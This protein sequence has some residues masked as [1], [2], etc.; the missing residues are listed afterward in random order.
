MDRLKRRQ[1]S[2]NK[3]L[4]K[5]IRSR[6]T[7]KKP[8]TT[9]A[10]LKLP[11]VS[12]RPQSSVKRQRLKVLGTVSLVPGTRSPDPFPALGSMYSL[13]SASFSPP[14]SQ[15]RNKQTRGSY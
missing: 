5:N 15:E 1:P 12:L 10:Y 9:A 3:G 11:T 6:S 8:Q 13:Q 4:L 7:P 2:H 14:P